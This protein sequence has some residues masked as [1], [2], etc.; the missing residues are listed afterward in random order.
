MTGFPCL[1][2]KIVLKLKDL[3][4]I[5]KA[6]TVNAPCDLVLILKEHK[7]RFVTSELTANIEQPQ[8]SISHF[9]SLFIQVLY[10]FNYL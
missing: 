10:M 9:G 2:V 7:N 1:R 5:M 4:I 6:T 8:A 3:P